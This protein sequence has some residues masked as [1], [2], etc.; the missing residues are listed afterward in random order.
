[1]FRMFF[2][3]AAFFFLIY[4]LRM[5]VYNACGVTGFAIVN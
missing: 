5:Y 3:L 2:S 4:E 1:M